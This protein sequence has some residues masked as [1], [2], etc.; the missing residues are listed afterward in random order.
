ML[1]VITLRPCVRRSVNFVS[2][3]VSSLVR[4]D[5]NEGK[6][7]LSIEYSAYEEMANKEIS[8]IRESAFSKWPLTCLHIYHSIGSVK[9]GEISMFIF[10]SSVHRKEC[11]EAMTEI[12][13]DVKFKVP[14]WKKEITGDKS[15]SWIS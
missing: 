13:E 11:I 10:V 6:K 1:C 8:K 7:T 4:A 2:A 5:E 3:V 9:T 15:H 12:V 14:I